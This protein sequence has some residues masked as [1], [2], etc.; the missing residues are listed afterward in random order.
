MEPAV[1]QEV[2]EIR[3][4]LRGGVER[5]NLLEPRFNRRMDRADQRM[6]RSEKQIQ[7]TRKLV[8]AGMK[9]VV[10]MSKRMDDLAK[11][12]AEFLRSMRYGRNGG[13]GHGSGRSR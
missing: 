3:G 5:G 7:A 9:I 8:D 13:N 4:L 2:R 10:R 11:A 1:Q 12:Q 6:E